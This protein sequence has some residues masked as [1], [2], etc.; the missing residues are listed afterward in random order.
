MEEKARI[1]NEEMK[2]ISSKKMCVQK[3]IEE[4]EEKRGLIEC[5]LRSEQS[6]LREMIISALKSGEEPSDILKQSL[7]E[8]IKCLE[9]Q[10]KLTDVELQALTEE[11]KSLD[12]NLEDA[13]SSHFGVV[14][15]L[16]AMQ[17]ELDGLL[18]NIYV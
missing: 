13:F 4:I 8:E 1:I 3:K 11:G 10:I 15:V 2:E 9:D 17:S 7:E 18:P 14:Q 16:Q 12:I 5:N 6:D